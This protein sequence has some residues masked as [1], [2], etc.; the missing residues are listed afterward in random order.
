MKYLFLCKRCY[1][2]PMSSGTCL[3]CKTVLTQRSQQKYCSNQCQADGRYE[4]FKNS[5]LVEQK[6]VVTLNISRHIKRYL[7][8]RSDEKCSVCKWNKRHP[9]T[10]KVP[11]EVDH[12]DG[13]SEN[14][15]LKNLRLLCPNCHSLTPFFRNLNKGNGRAWRRNTK[16]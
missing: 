4:S 2:T 12:I 5:W 16:T 7:V 6:A 10:N 9:I 14:N 1:T 15:N 13:D 3:V 11:L 8:E